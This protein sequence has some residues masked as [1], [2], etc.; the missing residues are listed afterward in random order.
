MSDIIIESLESMD[1]KDRAMR[2]KKF[3]LFGKK[4]EQNIEQVAEPVKVEEE[5]KVETANV[6][7]TVEEA[8]KVES[9]VAAETVEEAVKV[10]TVNATESVEEVVKADAEPAAETIKAETENAAE[11]IEEAVKV[12]SAVAAETVEEAAKVKTANA[13]ETAEEEEAEES[14]K[15]FLKRGL[16][17]FLIYFGIFALAIIF[18]ELIVRVQMGGGI[19]AGNLFFLCFVPAQAAVLAA[20]NGIFPKVVNR[21]T[22]PL[23]MLLVAVF[24]GIQMVYYRIFGSLLSVYLLGMGTDAVGNFWWAMQETMLK[25]IG[26]ILLLIVP[27]AAVL[28]LCLTKK[29][30]CEPYP[31]LI[32]MLALILGVGLWFGAANG[33]ILFG[34]GRSSAYYAFHSNISDTDTTASRVGTMTTTLVEAGSYYFGFG[35]DKSSTLTSVDMDSISLEPEPI[36]EK[37][38]EKKEEPVSETVKASE[39]A[40]EPEKEIEKIPYVYDGIDFNALAENTEDEALRDMYVYFGQRTPTTTN[41]YTGLMEGYNLIYICAESYWNYAL[42]EKVTPTLYK[43]SQN[44][45]V[46][47]NYY[48][49]FRNTTTNG[50]YAFST[51]LWPDVSRQADQGLE[52]GS[53]PQSSDKYMPNGLGDFFATENVPSYAFHNYYGFYYRRCLSWPN[54]GYENNYFMGKGMRFTSAWPA[55][56]AELMQQSVEKYIE[57]DRFFAY[58][59]TFSGHGPYNSSNYMYRKNI[60]EVKDRLG[61]DAKNY[62]DEALGYLAG[63]L[64]LEYGMEYLV[65]ELEKAGKMDKTLIV[66]AGDH[67]PYYLSENGR[68]NLAGTEIDE[69]ELYKSSCI[70]YT[71]GLEEPIVSDVYCCNVD[72]IPTVLN[73]FGI[74]FDSRLMMGTDIFSDGIHKAVLYDKSFVTDKVL[75]NAKTGDVEWKID[76]DAYDWKNLKSY[77]DNMSA[78]VDSEYTASVNIIKMN[79]YFH[80]W[81]DSGMMTEEEVAEEK[82]REASTKNQMDVLNAEDSQRRADYAAK[83]AEEA[84]AAAAAAQAAQQ[85]QQQEGAV[86]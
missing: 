18:W 84:A 8:V 67:Y 6:A 50:E 24:Y 32:H 80:L 65:D 68:N 55:S 4:K 10:E 16:V 76:P 1:K 36:S 86:E 7:E 47:N 62:T 79:F 42:N 57:E 40:S 82:Q 3:R 28:V 71:E 13:S 27:V 72:I 30:K 73:L 48:N 46:L 25:S 33:I 38:L 22:F 77:V 51:S 14:I 11:A 35:K 49:S 78:L 31:I 19:K 43:M 15:D 69:M 21:I 9:A 85:Q 2:R 26:F 53:F 61:D 54:L 81:E 44:G 64:E 29:I 70:M 41:E 37:V 56:D 75:Y 52:V 17:Q 63:N 34:D 74:K 83:K 20:I 60:Q 66:I 5:V 12:E 59:M 58:Y 23:T 39:I 45:I